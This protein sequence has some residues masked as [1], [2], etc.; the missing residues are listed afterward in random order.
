MTWNFRGC[1]GK[2]YDMIWIYG[3]YQVRSGQ[4]PVTSFLGSNF[5]S[6]NMQCHWDDVTGPWHDLTWLRPDVLNDLTLWEYQCMISVWS[7]TL[8]LS[9]QVRLLT[10]FLRTEN[11]TPE[12]T[13]QVIDL[14]WPDNN[15]MF[16]SCHIPLP[17]SP[18]SFKSFHQPVLKLCKIK[19]WSIYI[20][21]NGSFLLVKIYFATTVGMFYDQ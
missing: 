3:F 5:P 10:R 7:Y 9:G 20:K 15:L 16:I 18:E 17:G 11:W 4:W 2:A 14:T 19:E 13:S 1:Q 6:V 8:S 21:F 12:M